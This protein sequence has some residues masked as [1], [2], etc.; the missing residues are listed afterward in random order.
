M[1]VVYLDADHLGDP[2]FVPGLARDLAARPSGL[3]LVHGSGERGERALESQGL[4]PQS[5]DG[6]WRVDGERQRG[7]VE[8]ATRELNREMVHEFNEQGVV[9]VGAMAGD[10]GL[11]RVS[12]DGVEIGKSTWVADLVRQGVA[13]LVGTLVGGAEVDAATVAG[14]LAVA[15]G[16]TPMALS[17]RSVEADV[18]TQELGGLVYD[19][20][21]VQRMVESA[22]PVHLGLRAR[23]RSDV[24]E[25]PC[26]R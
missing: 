24:S 9:A 23:L 8:R 11:V 10:R 18:S 14:R 3:V 6:V 25:T 1:T 12:G 19:R 16:G 22:G 7:A 21:A 5:V 2:L 4:L 20:A 13:V 17:R 26:V 15:L